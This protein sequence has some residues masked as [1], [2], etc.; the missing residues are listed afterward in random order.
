M[1]VIIFNDLKGEVL[2]IVVEYLNHKVILLL[3]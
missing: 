3:I 2:E 1:P